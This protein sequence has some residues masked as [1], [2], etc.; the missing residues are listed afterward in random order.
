MPNALDGIKVLD[1]SHVLS[2]PYGTM[3]LADMGA[4]VLKV[5]SIGS[6]DAL[7]GTPPR[8][9]TLSAYYFCANRNKRCLAV[10]LKKPE[11]KEIV[12]RIAKDCDIFVENF[13]PGVTERLGFGYEDIKKV[14]PDVIYASLSAFGDIGP[15]KD[16]PGFELIIQSLGGLVSVT[17]GRDGRPSKVQPQVVDIGGGL[18]LAIAILGAIVHRQ[19]TGQGQYVKTSLLEGLIGLMTNFIYM[20]LWDYKIPYRFE[21]RNPMMF[22]SQSFKTKDGYFST[23]VVPDH[24]PRFCRALGKPEWIE[25]P[26]YRNPVYRVQ[27]Y[28]EME[29]MVEEMTRQKTTAEWLG[30]LEKEDVACSQINTVEQMLEDP[31][32]KALDLFR[33][34]S[35]PKY[36]EFKVQIPPWHMSETPPDIKRLPPGYGEHTSQVLAEFGYSSA[37]IAKLKEQRVVTG[38]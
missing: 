14:R 7:R 6:G 1:L 34:V 29:A 10:D 8:K 19:R 27:H 25:H 18:Y 16:K 38:E 24:W 32:I 31:Q 15:Y 30:I 13:R 11:G 26:D 22:P 3:L 12:Y 28:S 2:A 23:V 5:E 20:H 33:T 37:D 4:D 21:T 9:N 36:G 17:T 35:H